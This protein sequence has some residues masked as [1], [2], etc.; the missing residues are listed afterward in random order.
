MIECIGIH[1]KKGSFTPDGKKEEVA[2]D[3]IMV[4]YVTD[5]NPDVFGFYGV[6][7]KIPRARVQ[8]INFSDWK[9][10]VGKQIEFVYNIFTGTPRLTGVKIIGEGHVFELISAIHTGKMK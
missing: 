8:M 10:I 1:E 6:E 2:Y 7:I 3:N 4:Y 9:E 5:D